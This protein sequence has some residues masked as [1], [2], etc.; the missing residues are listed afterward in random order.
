MYSV[1]S[2]VFACAPTCKRIV[3]HTRGALQ[4]SLEGSEAV[5]LPLALPRGVTQ[6]SGSLAPGNGQGFLPPEY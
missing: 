6:S 1:H 3:T 4:L 5:T 2:S